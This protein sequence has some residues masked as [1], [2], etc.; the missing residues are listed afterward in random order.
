MLADLAHSSTPR[1]VAGRLRL[2]T[3]DAT[4]KLIKG[5][6]PFGGASASHEVIYQFIY[7]IPRGELAPHGVFMRSKRTRRRPRK[8]TGQRGAPIAGVVSIDDRDPGAADRRVPGHWV[9]W[10]SARTARPRP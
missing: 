10:S 1:Q 9:I 3:V 8:A 5:S 7:A 4:V 2:E 6:L